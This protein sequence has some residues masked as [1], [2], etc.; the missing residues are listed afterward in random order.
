MALPSPLPNWSEL[1]PNR[2]FARD[3]L[4]IFGRD[5]VLPDNTTVRLIIDPTPKSEDNTEWV[6]YLGYI[7]NDTTYTGTLDEEQ[8]IRLGS[9]TGQPYFV[10]NLHREK[11]GWLAASLII[12]SA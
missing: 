4:R 9:A 3:L 1:G 11:N 5:F 2:N 10:A 6:E 7:P 8:T 12:H